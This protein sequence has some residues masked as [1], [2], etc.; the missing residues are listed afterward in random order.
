MRRSR[1]ISMKTRRSPQTL[2]T[3]Q[4]TALHK[5]GD[6]R[7]NKQADYREDDEKRKAEDVRNT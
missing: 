5:E 7:V 3:R 4:I 6:K 2:I 1:G